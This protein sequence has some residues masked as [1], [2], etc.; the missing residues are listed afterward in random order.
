MWVGPSK[1]GIPH[2]L[3][4]MACIRHMFICYSNVRFFHL[5]LPV[6]GV[7]VQVEYLFIDYCV[8]DLNQVFHE[9]EEVL[10]GLK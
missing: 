5:Q 9:G 10:V 7:I 6:G 8:I 1:R 4:I 3:S 2:K